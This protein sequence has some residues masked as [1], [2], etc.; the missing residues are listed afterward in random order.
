MSRLGMAERSPPRATSCSK[1]RSTGAHRLQRDHGREA[2]GV[3]DRNRRGG[4]SG[5]LSGGRRAVPVGRGRLGWRVRAGRAR[6]RVQQPGHGL[7]LRRGRHGA[8]AGLHQAPDGRLLA[9]AKYDPA[10]VG[11]DT[12]RNLKSILF[13]GPFKS[14][15]MPDFTGKLKDDDMVKIIA[16]IQGTADAMRPKE[17]AKTGSK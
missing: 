4:E 8:V 6:D 10:D 2:L 16:F 17:P 12:I 5:N 15:G 14:Q 3:A 7:Y 13:D 9:G 1:G 11:A